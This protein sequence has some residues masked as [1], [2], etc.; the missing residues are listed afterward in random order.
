MF[1]FFSGV[2]ISGGTSEASGFVSS[3]DYYCISS[4]IFSG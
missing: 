1:Y 3:F 2:F 4:S